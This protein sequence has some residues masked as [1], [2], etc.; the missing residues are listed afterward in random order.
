MEYTFLE[1]PLPDEV[2]KAVLSYL[3]RS[4]L[5]IAIVEEKHVLTKGRPNVVVV[6]KACSVGAVSLTEDGMVLV[7][8]TRIKMYLDMDRLRRKIEDHLRKSA[9]RKDIIRIATYLGLDL[10]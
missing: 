1:C 7:C 2:M 5:T 10:K 8:G 4:G 3:R 9:S 6:E